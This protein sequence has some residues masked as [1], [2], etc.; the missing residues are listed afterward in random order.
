MGILGR[1][2]MFIL[3]WKIK[4]IGII[5]IF[6]GIIIYLEL[7]K[8][9]DISIAKEKAGHSIWK[10]IRFVNRFSCSFIGHQT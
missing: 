1:K 10:L 9:D 2:I 8:E 7:D 3:E 4:K 6:L 5:R